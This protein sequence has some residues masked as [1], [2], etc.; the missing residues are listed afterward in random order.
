MKKNDT[1]ELLKECNSGIKMGSETINS[2]IDVVENEELKQ[3]LTDSAGEHEKL[4]NET[5]SLL[6]ELGECG[7]DP[8]LAAV[9]MSKIKT[10][11]VMSL[12]KDDKKIASLVTDGCSMGVKSLNKYLNQYEN[13]SHKAKQIAKRLIHAEQRL[14]EDLGK[15]L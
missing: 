1:A 15:F 10:E 4:G 13:A 12:G 2:V 14:C 11:L 8:S 6:T 9:G 3:L 7:K 5:H